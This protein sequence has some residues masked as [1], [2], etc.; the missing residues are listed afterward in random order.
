MSTASIEQAWSR[1]RV[2][3]IL[4]EAINAGFEGIDYEALDK[5]Y[6]KWIDRL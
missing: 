1:E 2:E 5:A 4:K 6:L 3:E